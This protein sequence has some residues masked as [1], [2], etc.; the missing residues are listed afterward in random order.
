M[1]EI[2]RLLLFLNELAR[3]KTSTKAF[4][5]LSYQSAATHVCP[6][7]ERG[8]A[9]V[10]SLSVALEHNTV[11]HAAALAPD[12]SVQDLTRYFTSLKF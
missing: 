5:R 10:A 11:T 1:K 6:W 12:H 2:E 8:N 3:Y 4:V 7:V 9:E